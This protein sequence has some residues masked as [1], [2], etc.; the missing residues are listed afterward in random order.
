V[1]AGIKN[2][3]SSR[4]ILNMDKQRKQLAKIIEAVANQY[5]CINGTTMNIQHLREDMMTE[6]LGYKDEARSLNKQQHELLSSVITHLMIAQSELNK[7][8]I[9]TKLTQKAND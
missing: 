8:V 5:F 7:Y 1:S 4:G 9:D 3:T 2:R 6:Y